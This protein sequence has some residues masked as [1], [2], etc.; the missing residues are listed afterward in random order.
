MNFDKKKTNNCITLPKWDLSWHTVSR[1]SEWVSQSIIYHLLTWDWL[2]VWET[3]EARQT[4]NDEQTFFNISHS[5]NR[6]KTNINTHDPELQKNFQFRH[7]LTFNRF[8]RHAFI[9]SFIHSFISCLPFKESWV[10]DIHTNWFFLFASIFSCCCCC[11]LYF[12][13]FFFGFLVFIVVAI[14]DFF[15]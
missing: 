2:G 5:H 12:F 13:F 14:V 11:F 3:I 9:C 7:Y 1:T 6:Y 10:I 15:F 8:V 4:I